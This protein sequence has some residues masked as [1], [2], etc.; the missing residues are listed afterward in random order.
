MR[1]R[2]STEVQSYGWGNFVLLFWVNVFGFS[3]RYMDM[4][5]NVVPNA[6]IWK[7]PKFDFSIYLPK[8]IKFCFEIFLGHS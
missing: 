2:N 1:K 7:I 5:K 8:M 3:E 4:Y 6:D